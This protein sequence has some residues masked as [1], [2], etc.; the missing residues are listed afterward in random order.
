MYRNVNSNVYPNYL[1]ALD[2]FSVLTGSLNMKDTSCRALG[3][4]ARV[5]RSYVQSGILA[6]KHKPCVLVENRGLDSINLAFPLRFPT[7]RQERE[8][9]GAAVEEASAARSS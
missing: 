3:A 9:W 8:R 2:R 7:G 6:P 5:K 4:R 1:H